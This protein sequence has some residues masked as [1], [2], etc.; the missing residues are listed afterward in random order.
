[1]IRP[2]N[3]SDYDEI[4]RVWLEASLQAHSFIP[5]E[6]WHE[7]CSDMREVWLPLSDILLGY[8]DDTKGTLV[9]FAALVDD[10]LAALF[11]EP[12]YQGQG[13]G[14]RLLGTAI[15]ICPS[16][17]LT[18]YAENIRAIA[19]YTKYGFTCVDE[20]TEEDTGHTVY[21]MSRSVA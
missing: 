15:K 7:H 20:R 14:S 19:F 17:S 12:Q 2:L 11:V 3:E 21:V 16:L 6:Y 5:L 8:V 13:I 9:G 10:A 1:M 18:V 4:V